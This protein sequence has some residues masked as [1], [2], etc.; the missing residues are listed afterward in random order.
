MDTTETLDSIIAQPPTPEPEVAP[1]GTPVAEAAGTDEMV[2][3]TETEAAATDGEQ[4]EGEANAEE[5]VD[6]THEVDLTLPQGDGA[7]RGRIKLTGV[8]QEVADTIR[9]HQKQSARVPKMEQQLT[10]ATDKAALLDYLVKAPVDGMLG[11]AG[12]SPQAAQ[13]FVGL[14][15]KANPQSFATIAKSLGLTVG[16][17]EGVDDRLLMAEAK[18]AQMEQDTRVKAGRGSFDAHRAVDAYSN[19]ATGV[20]EEF[21][22]TIGL[23][24]TP[25]AAGFRAACEK[26]LVDLYRRNPRADRAAILSA[27]Q[28]MVD[29]FTTQRANAAKLRT[30]RVG[31]AQSQA[32]DVAGKFADKDAKAQKFR[33]LGGGTSAFTPM[34]Q[35]KLPPGTTLDDIIAGRVS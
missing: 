29:A 8:S 28:P 33:K 17:G 22:D 14:W 34:S 30:Q 12:E 5:D 4:P 11:L 13:E 23:S 19:L 31:Q 7:D 15:L 9:F 20:V 25:L 3:P 16:Y 2:A 1:T 6:L 32:R 35:E 27:I 21:V 18:V 10:E 26:D 24:D